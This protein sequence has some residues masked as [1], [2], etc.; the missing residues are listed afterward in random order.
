MVEPNRK[1]HCGK[2]PKAKTNLSGRFCKERQERLQS[3]LKANFV[4]SPERVTPKETVM[5]LLD[6]SENEK[7]LAT[8]TVNNTFPTASLNKHTQS[9]RNIRKRTS[10]ELKKDSSDKV[11]PIDNTDISNIQNLLVES[12]QT[13]AAMLNDIISRVE[14]G[15][16]E[17]IQPLLEA[18]R[19]QSELVT[20]YSET[21]DKLYEKEIKSLMVEREGPS[22]SELD[23]TK[24]IQ[25]VETLSKTVNIGIEEWE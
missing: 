11:Y 13:N 15:S 2:P 9:Y 25:D 21:L 3:V 24:L 18:H 20:H 17:H 22:L 14:T 5:S 12:R 16:T 1:K 6:L 4:E 8:R 7:G 10:F 23:K 19:K